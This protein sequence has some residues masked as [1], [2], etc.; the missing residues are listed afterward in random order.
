MLWERGNLHEAAVVQDLGIPFLDLS[1]LA[2][3]EREE[4]TSLAME[5]Q[6]ELIYGGRI[7]SDNLLG[8]PDLLRFES[9]CYIAGDIKYI[10]N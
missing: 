3:D 4:R 5:E 1:R 7:S 6:V 2:G 10:K 8:D 9:T